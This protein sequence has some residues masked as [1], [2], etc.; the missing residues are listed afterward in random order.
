PILGKVRGFDEA[1]PSAAGL[2]RDGAGRSYTT[3]GYANGPGHLAASN[4]QPAGTKRFPHKPSHQDTAAVPRPDLD[5]VDTTDPDYLQESAVPM[6]DETHGGEDVAVFARGPGAEGVHGSFEQNALFH[7]MVQ[8]SPP[9]RRL[10]CRRGDCSDG[11]LPDRL[12]AAST[13]AH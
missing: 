2:R 5:D 3:L 12:P 7:L 1:E 13:T 4:R 6:K 8:A 9:I 10:L 11:T